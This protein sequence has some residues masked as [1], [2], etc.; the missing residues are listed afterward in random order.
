MFSWTFNAKKFRFQKFY[1]CKN[2]FPKGLSKIRVVE[3]KV[4]ACLLTQTYTDQ[5]DRAKVGGWFGQENAY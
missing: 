5:E 4:V 3:M 2:Q 1:C